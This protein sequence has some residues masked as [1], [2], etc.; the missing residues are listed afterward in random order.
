MRLSRLAAAGVAAAGMRFFSSGGPQI[1][2]QLRGRRFVA[3]VSGGDE[4][5]HAF[6][7]FTPFGAGCARLASAPEFSVPA[8]AKL[9]FFL[10]LAF[11]F[12]GASSSEPNCGGKKIFQ[13]G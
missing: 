7:T 8:S 4:N 1:S 9:A 3:S 11:F 5:E 6:F 10:V 2:T 12:L 13:K